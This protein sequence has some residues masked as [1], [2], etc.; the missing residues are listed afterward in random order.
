MKRALPTLLLMLLSAA[1][2]SAESVSYFDEKRAQ[3]IEVLGDIVAENP[4]EVVVKTA[5][6]EVTIPVHKILGIKY[7][8]QPK[9]LIN[10]RNLERQGRYDEAVAALAKVLP[11]IEARDQLLADALE[12]ELFENMAKQALADPTKREAALKRFEEK[13][14]TFSKSRHHYPSLEWAGRL[15]LDAGN[16]DQ[17][18]EL[19]G[20]LGSLDWPGYK[21]KSKVYLA[22]AEL[23]KGRAEDASRIFDE[24]ISSSA[25]GKTA[26]EQKR[27]ARLGKAEALIGTGKPAE[28]EALC[29]QVIANLPDDDDVAAAET[30]NRLGDSLRAQGKTKEAVLDGYLWV[31]TLYPNQSAEHAKALYYLA[32][33]FKEIGYPGYS[34]QM[35]EMLKSSFGQSDWAQKLSAGGS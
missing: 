1:S 21:E 6:E 22:T 3:G 16:Y 25:E 26:D 17:A 13:S 29:R 35:K 18:T 14:K 20:K 19:L 5:K 15:Q 2:L 10:I 31:H 11:D 9:D 28:A 27:L 34:D 24:V 8:R 23:K 33:M 32:T 30:R 4:R 12:Y 7:D